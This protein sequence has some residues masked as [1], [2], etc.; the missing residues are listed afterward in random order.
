MSSDSDDDPAGTA[1]TRQLCSSRAALAERVLA[2][3]REAVL[4]AV[5]ERGSASLVVT[6]GSTAREVYPALAALELPWQRVRLALSDERM[7]HSS[8]TDSNERLVR[9]CLLQGP[10]SAAELVPLYC[11]ADAARGATLSAAAARLATLV[12]PFDLV[13]LGM[14]VDSH[15]ASLFPGA[16]GVEAALAPVNAQSCCTV[17]PPPGVEPALPRLSLTL[18]TLMDS[19]RIVIMATGAAKR[20]AF[21][22][23]VLGDWPLPSPV[24]ALAVHARAPLDFIW[25][26]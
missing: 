9:E 20:A 25:S 21:E 13:L 12:R 11:E 7:V 23:A 3:V 16:S 2:A 14:G 24:H 18:A 1:F 5:R 26:P 19:R 4:G 22:R 8:H 15:I 17:L 10:A 6:G